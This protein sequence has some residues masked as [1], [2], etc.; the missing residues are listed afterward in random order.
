[1]SIAESNYP[2]PIILERI[3][4]EKGLKKNFIAEKAGI[5]PMMLSDILAGRR[6]VRPREIAALADAVGVEPAYL[7]DASTIENE[8]ASE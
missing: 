1:M 6:V 3:I 5:T 7:L 2:I 8:E 4:A